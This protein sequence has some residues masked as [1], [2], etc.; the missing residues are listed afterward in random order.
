MGLMEDEEFELNLY[1]DHK[2]NYY[3]KK[4]KFFEATGKKTSIMSVR[5]FLPWNYP[6]NYAAFFFVEIWLLY[7]KMYLYF[8]IYLVID[9]AMKIM[10]SVFNFNVNIFLELG[11]PHVF[12]GFYGNWLYYIHAKKKI[13]KI[14]IKYQDPKTQID[15]I[16]KAGGT[17]WVIAVGVGVFLLPFLIRILMHKPQ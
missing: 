7:R 14:K 12:L 2:N 9:I 17:N 4:W 3:G 15:E 10:V 13:A 11:V 5:D 1:G 6:V 16:T 8:L